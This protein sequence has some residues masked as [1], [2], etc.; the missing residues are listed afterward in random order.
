MFAPDERAFLRNRRRRTGVLAVE[1]FWDLD[2]TIKVEAEL[3]Q[4]EWWNGILRRIK[5]IL[6]IKAGVAQKFIRSG[7]VKSSWERLP[8]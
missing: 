5:E 1:K 7:V 3:V 8:S 2:R 4:F 6:R